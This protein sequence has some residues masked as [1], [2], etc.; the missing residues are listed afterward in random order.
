MTLPGKREMHVEKQ[1]RLKETVVPLGGWLGC[2]G[3]RLGVRSC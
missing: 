1:C 3:G 2:S